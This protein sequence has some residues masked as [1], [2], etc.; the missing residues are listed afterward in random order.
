MCVRVHMYMCVGVCVWN[1]ALMP[2]Q[3]SI[4]PWTPTVIYVKILSSPCLIHPFSPLLLLLSLFFFPLSAVDSSHPDSHVPFLPL[5]P[6]PFCTVRRCPSFALSLP[7][8][9]LHASLPP[10]A[11]LPAL[12]FPPSLSSRIDLHFFLLQFAVPLSLLSPLHTM[13]SLDSFILCLVSCPPPLGWT[14]TRS[15]KK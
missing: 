1:P 3:C 14:D 2:S 15:C 5:S 13:H 11:S 8:S 9:L 4:V 7:L 12:F 6:L 10:S